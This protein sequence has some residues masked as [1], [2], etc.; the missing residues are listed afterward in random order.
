M[1]KI[2]IPLS[3]TKIVLGVFGALCFVIIGLFFI[4]NSEKIISPIMTDPKII[5]IVGVAGVLF[6]GAASIYGFKKM[7][8]KNIG[9]TI[10]EIGIIDNTHAASIGLIRWTDITEITTKQVMSTKFFLIFTKNP[11]E[12][13]ENVSVVKRKLMIANMKMFGT[14]LSITTTSLKYNFND[15]E[16]LLQDRLKGEHE[17]MPNR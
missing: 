4:I 9:L 15:L 1:N 6:F 16:K 11:T 3:K 13:L 14:P 2:E 8:D 5:W 17:R 12:I 7:F 10:D